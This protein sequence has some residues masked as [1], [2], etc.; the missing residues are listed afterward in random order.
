MTYCHTSA[1]VANYAHRMGIQQLEEIEQEKRMLDSLK[2]G[3]KYIQIIGR[4]HCRLGI[5][6]VSIASAYLDG[7][8]KQFARENSY[9]S[10]PF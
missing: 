1:Q 9:F 2:M 10:R 6:P 7:Y 4:R 8:S 5:K 3:K